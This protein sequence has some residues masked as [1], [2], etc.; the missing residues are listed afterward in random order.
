MKT[1]K[2]TTAYVFRTAMCGGGTS[3]DVYFLTR[4]KPS[5]PLHGGYTY[6]TIISRA[7]NEFYNITDA[8]MPKSVWAMDCGWEKFDAHRRLEKVAGRLAVRI[9]SQVCPELRG[10]RELP[11]LWAQWSF[12]SAIYPV[13][14]RIT[15]PE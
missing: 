15:L 4:D 6:A 11:M 9:A 14:V 7:G 2:T 8:I 10:R 1:T 12:P 5:R 13:I 3:Y